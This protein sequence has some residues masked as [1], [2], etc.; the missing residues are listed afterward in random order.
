MF[1]SEMEH[2]ALMTNVEA[3]A[4]CEIYHDANWMMKM[5]EEAWL[6]KEAKLLI[7]GKGGSLEE[8]QEKNRLKRLRKAS[9]KR[10]KT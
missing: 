2:R 3:I 8:R 5:D 9:K 6:E 1:E 10:A 7:N 4:R